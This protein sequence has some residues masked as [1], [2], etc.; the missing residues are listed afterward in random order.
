MPDDHP[1]EGRAEITLG[2][3]EVP[4]AQSSTTELTVPAAVSDR[5][6]GSWAGIVEFGHREGWI[7]PLIIRTDVEEQRLGGVAL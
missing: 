6:T 5:C 7:Q 3:A 1:R 4:P 2:P